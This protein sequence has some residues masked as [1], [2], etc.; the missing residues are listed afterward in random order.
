MLQVTLQ[1]FRSDLIFCHLSSHPKTANH[2][3]LPSSSPSLRVVAAKAA[4]RQWQQQRRHGNVMAMPV[5]ARWRQCNS[6]AVVEGIARRQWWRDIA[7][8][9]VARLQR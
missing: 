3:L 7:A 8:V 4:A 9:A 6:V 5:T 2:G 1:F